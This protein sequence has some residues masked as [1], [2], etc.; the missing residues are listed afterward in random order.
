[1]QPRAEKET[2]HVPPLFSERR[3]AAA[4]LP[5]AAP[6]KDNEGGQESV[7]KKHGRGDF[8]ARRAAHPR[9]SWREPSG[10]PAATPW[11]ARHCQAIPALG[12]AARAARGERRTAGQGRKHRG[13]GLDR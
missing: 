7:E 6:R 12:R 8:R 10:P 1:M 2:A 13:L 9:D 3:A 11:V 5:K 4:C